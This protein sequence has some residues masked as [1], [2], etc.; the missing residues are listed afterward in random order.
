[1]GFYLIRTVGSIVSLSVLAFIVHRQGATGSYDYLIW[2]LAFEAT[3]VYGFWHVS[4]TGFWHFFTE[5]KFYLTLS[6]TLLTALILTV[7]T[8]FSFVIPGS[9]FD[10]FLLWIYTAVRVHQDY[11]H[12]VDGNEMWNHVLLPALLAF[13][14]VVGLH[15]FNPDYLQNTLHWVIVFYV[16]REVIDWGYDLLR[17]ALKREKR[18]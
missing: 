17:H 5:P 6:V 18:A 13:T 16:V 2:T 4:H 1:M 8:I 9:M 14:T 10:W 15:Q 12:V 7:G 11:V 3:V